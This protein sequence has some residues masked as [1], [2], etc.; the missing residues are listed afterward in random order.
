MLA[1]YGVGGTTTEDRRTTDALSLPCLSL[2]DLPGFFS[3]SFLFSLLVDW[4]FP[5]G[6]PCP[7]G[8][9]YL[10][11]LKPN[12]KGKGHK[13][14]VAAD[15]TG[16]S[17]QGAASTVYAYTD[18]RTHICLQ[19]PQEPRTCHK[20][21]CTTHSRHI[22]LSAWHHV[23]PILCCSNARLGLRSALFALRSPPF[24]PFPLIIRLVCLLHSLVVLW[25]NSMVDRVLAT[26]GERPPLLLH[27][28]LA[29]TLVSRGILLLCPLRRVLLLCLF[30]EQ[31]CVQICSLLLVFLVSYHIGAGFGGQLLYP[32]HQKPGVPSL[33]CFRG[34]P[35]TQP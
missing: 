21:K 3:L 8:G 5:V 16:G 4:T 15:A 11:P 9:I 17:T 7:S 35:E 12:R 23:H 25:S 34:Q 10:K 20:Q 27:S 13:R 22:L 14:D 26:P 30:R 24:R 32:P 1:L 28:A 2:V 19:A 31:F 18:Y 29:W 33:A 6:N